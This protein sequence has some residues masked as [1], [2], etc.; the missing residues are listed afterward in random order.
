MKNKKI[1]MFLLGHSFPPDIRVEKE[2][3]VLLKAGYQISLLC[4]KKDK[5]DKEYEELDLGLKIYRCNVNKNYIKNRFSTFFINKNEYNNVISNFIKTTKPNI[6]HI[7]DLTFLP[8]IYKLIPK[9]I[10]IIADLHENMPAAYKVYRTNNNIFNKILLGLPEYY[11]W[12]YVENKYLPKCDMIFNVVEEATERLKK[13]NISND[14]IKVISNTENE[15]TFKISEIDKSIVEKYKKFWTILYIGGIGPH[16]GIE[17]A[18]KAIGLCKNKIPNLKLLIVGCRDNNSKN[19]LH[20]I[21]MKSGALDN[22]EILDW[23]DS[24]KVQSYIAAAKVGIIPHGDF[25]HTHTT[26]PHK[27]FQYMMLSKPVI[28]SDCKPLKRIVEDCNCGVIFKASN[29]LHCAENIIELHNSSSDMLEKF[30][31]NAFNSAIGKYS[32]TNDEKS[33]LEAYQKLLNK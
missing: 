25:E 11:L 24:N 19:H 30:S 28:V 15:E 9:G 33:L 18:I 1:S 29:S 26:V 16:R 4:E 10:K 13:Y 2:V 22:I 21:A 32:W 5:N 14:K 12:K 27:L 23:V 20:N 8:T 7:H 6:I 3:S 31:K 17:D